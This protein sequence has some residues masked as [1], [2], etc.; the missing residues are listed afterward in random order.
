MSKERN[1]LYQE[2]S[3]KY[4]DL[5]TTIFEERTRKEQQLNRIL[6]D[7]RLRKYE[8]DNIVT[9]EISNPT[10][11]QENVQSTESLRE[12]MLSAV[13]LPSYDPI[14]LTEDVRVL[15]EGISSL[16]AKGPS[17]VPTQKHVD[18]L[19]LQKDFD[20]FK[21]TIR[22]KVFFASQEGNGP[23]NTTDDFKPPKKPS[24]W[25]APKSKIDEVE[26]FI[27]CVEKD[28]FQTTT[29]KPRYDNLSK[30][31][32][33]SLDTWRKEFLFKPESDLVMRL[34]DKGN[35]FVLVDKQTDLEKAKDQIARSAFRE[36]DEDPTAEHIEIV[37]GWAQ[38]WVKKKEISEAW[39]EYVINTKATPGK[40][41]TLYKTHKQG[42]PVRLLT[43][44]CN[45]AIENLSRF[46]ER[47][48]AP[49]TDHIPSRIKDNSHMLQIVDELNEVGLPRNTV[50]ISLDIVN[51][52]PNI[53]NVKGMKAVEEALNMRP[54]SK[55]STGCVMDALSICL[56]NNNSVFA[57]QHLLQVNGTATGAPNSCSYSDLAVGAI[58]NKVNA[59][60]LSSFKEVL[61]YGRYRDDIFILWNGDPSRL[62]DFLDFMNS[63]DDKLKFTL[64][65]GGE[66]LTFLDLLL[67]LINGRLETTVYS[68]P[69]DSHLYLHAMSCHKKA[70]LEGI[71][72]GVALRLRR[73]C[74]R[75][76]DFE[77]KAKEYSAYLVGRGHDPK[78]VRKNFTEV[79]KIPR[80]VARRKKNQDSPKNRIIFSTQFVPHG[81]DIGKIIRKH[82]HLLQLK[83]SNIFP[84]RSILVAHKRGK[85]LKDL[86]VRGDPYNMKSDLNGIPT[87]GYKKCN[88]KCESCEYFVIPTDEVVSFA[89]SKTYKVRRELSC[90]AKYIVYM[91][92]C[93]LCREQGV[94]STFDWKPRMR[95]YKSHI[96]KGRRTCRIVNHF[97]DVHKGFQNIRFILLDCVDNVDGLSIEQIDDLL[98]EKEKFWIGTLVTQHKGLNSTHDWVR[99]K[100]NDKEKGFE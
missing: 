33:S 91:A 69:T 30:A 83:T 34:Q 87:G 45:S 51:M 17:F 2:I 37:K 1:K 75:D 61:Y 60:R 53:D 88:R 28:I 3:S 92:F 59:A 48:C 71:Q 29:V 57:N 40:N 6:K 21:N 86:M 93:L 4:P 99:T 26:A 68:K 27:S 10:H 7:R 96:S 14:I 44:G 23:L 41:A 31:E 72:K 85:N 64:V 98:L 19:Q 62:K 50:L 89:S 39:G 24:S 70:S 47:V 55:P 9:D 65:V 46:V 42:N 36:L 63:L 15:P 16:C 95:N 18:W 66:S 73:I 81:P 8:R 76:E 25:R 12:E 54:N 79:G 74:S 20:R 52:F 22:A 38:K 13:D 94:G 11:F 5:V 43:T 56:Y 90:N 58:D 100:R 49:L 82:Q 77:M 67:R 80:D 35:R 84:D 97:I 32:R 78:V